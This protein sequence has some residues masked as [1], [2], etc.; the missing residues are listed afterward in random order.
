MHLIGERYFLY[1]Y[2]VIVSLSCAV[3]SGLSRGSSALVGKNGRSQLGRRAREMAMFS[4]LE[5]EPG[6]EVG[7]ILVVFSTALIGLRYAEST[8]LKA[9]KTTRMTLQYDNANKNCTRYFIFKYIFSSLIVFMTYIQYIYYCNISCT[10]QF[11]R[12]GCLWLNYFCNI[13]CGFA[14][15]RAMSFLP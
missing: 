5:N 10:T 7:V 12:L 9:T 1:R 15:N 6:Y 14:E 13:F 3:W 8:Y 11:V 4:D 2:L